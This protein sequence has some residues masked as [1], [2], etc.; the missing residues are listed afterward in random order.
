M[1]IQK[2]EFYEGAALHRLL[3]GAVD[4]RIRCISPLFVFDD[5]IQV[6]LKYSTGKR[7]PWG[8]TFNPDEQLMLY[9]R[10]IELPTVIGLVCGSDGVAALPFECYASIALHR[11]TA[12]RVACYRQHREFYEISGPDAVLVQKIPPSNWHTLLGI[13]ND[14]DAE[15]TDDAHGS[16]PGT[17]AYAGAKR[18]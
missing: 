13:R 6:H 11:P 3:R 15:D 16:G 9:Q 10:S 2:K 4:A 1:T 8:F 7:S 17:A 14:Y 12:V 18:D 5:R